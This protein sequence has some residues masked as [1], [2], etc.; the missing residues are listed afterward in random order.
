MNTNQ[1][2]K[3]TEANV[4]SL[5]DVSLENVHDPSG[6]TPNNPSPTGNAAPAATAPVD[7]TKPVEPVT[8]AV[9]PT[10]PAD[11]TPPATTPDDNTTTFT[12][13]TFE[14][15]TKLLTSKTSDQLSEEENN[16]LSDIVDAFGGTAFNDKGEIV[17]A[18]NNILFTADQLKHYL[19]TNELPVDDNGD[20]VDANG[21]IVKSKVELFRENTTVGTVMNAL[22]RN[23]EVTFADTFM[24][25]DTEDS[26]VDVVNKVVGVVEQGSVERYMRANPE[27]DAARKHLQLHGSLEGYNSSAVDYDKIDVKVLSKE[28]KGIYIADAYKATGRTLTPAYSK[29]LEGLDEETYNA[30]VVDNIKVLKDIQT[31]KQKEVDAQLKAQAAQRAQ[32]AKQYW[33]SV[34]TTIKNGKISNINIPIPERDAFLAYV[35]TPVKDGRTKDMLDAEKEDINADLLMSYLRYKG[36][37]LSVLAKN[38][39]TTQ[40]VQSLREKMGRNNRR[41]IS[42][43]GKGHRPT[44]QNNDYIPN[45]SEVNL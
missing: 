23:F 37:D 4:T 31:N 39:A 36:Y 16:E 42:N 7:P 12:I 35:T 17:D 24:P 34:E 9:D 40:Q 10:K 19:E 41:N 33:D 22:S 44:T 43:S 13:A 11:V 3:P 1:V 26:L 5:D 6:I 20:F 28:A 25:D 2:N 8:P 15:L 45:L 27:L 14:D 30:E 29:Y 38:I 32:E 21:N 18:E